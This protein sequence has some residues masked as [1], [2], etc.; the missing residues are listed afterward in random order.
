M[1]WREQMGGVSA[2]ETD[3]CW[4]CRKVTGGPQVCPEISR[5]LV[6]ALR[7]GVHLEVL[8]CPNYAPL[9]GKE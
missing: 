8:Y 5:G 1:F 9:L 4:S 2:G 6:K 7:A 3:S